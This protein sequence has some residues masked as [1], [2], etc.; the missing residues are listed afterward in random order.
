MVASRKKR[1]VISSKTLLFE[2]TY[3]YIRIIHE[4]PVF[5]ENV[6]YVYDVI[7]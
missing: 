2:S 4:L 5:V 1:T 7:L 3:H 6:V